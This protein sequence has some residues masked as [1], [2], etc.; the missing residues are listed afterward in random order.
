[1]SITPTPLLN[2]RLRLAAGRW[3]MVCF[4]NA[5]RLAREAHTEVQMKTFRR[6][7][8]ESFGGTHTVRCLYRARNSQKGN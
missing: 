2:V 7:T 3:V 5:E 8:W 4:A 1:M 6:R